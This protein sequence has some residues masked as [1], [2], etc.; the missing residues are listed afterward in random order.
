[1]YYQT[2]K[3]VSCESLICMMGPITLIALNSISQSDATQLNTLTVTN[4]RSCVAHHFG[5]VIL[6]K[7]IDH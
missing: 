1:M 4:Y 3:L 5:Q 7:N 2:S 6:E